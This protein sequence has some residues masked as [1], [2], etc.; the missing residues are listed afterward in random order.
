MQQER[1]TWEEVRCLGSESQPPSNKGDDT[2]IVVHNRCILF[3]CFKIAE[4]LPEDILPLRQS[5][6]QGSKFCH[7]IVL[8]GDKLGMPTTSCGGYDA[9]HR[10]TPNPVN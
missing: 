6:Q 9:N 1:Y 10:L 3:K 4:K 7:E 2:N 5:S 8:T